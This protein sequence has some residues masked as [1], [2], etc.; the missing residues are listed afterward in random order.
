MKH[1]YKITVIIVS[2]IQILIFHLETGG[3]SSALLVSINPAFLN[4]F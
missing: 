4:T 3:N 1:Y 2:V